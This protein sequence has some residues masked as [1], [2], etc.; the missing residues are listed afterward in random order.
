M[1]TSLSTLTRVLVVAAVL[2]F[3]V[4]A[5]RASASG[6]QP[7]TTTRTTARSKTETPANGRDESPL[8]GLLIIAG[9]I[10]AIVVLAWVASRMGDNRRSDTVS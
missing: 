4:E 6:Q 5:S 9:I 10:G 1:L 3:A 2:G 8:G 7:Q